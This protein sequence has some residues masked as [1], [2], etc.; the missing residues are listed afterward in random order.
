MQHNVKQRNVSLV[1]DCSRLSRLRGRVMV[2]YYSNINSKIAPHKLK[3]KLFK[4]KLFYCFDKMQLKN[5]FRVSRKDKLDYD[6]LYS[7]IT[8]HA[9]TIR[10]YSLIL[11]I[12]FK[13]Q[14]MM[15]ISPLSDLLGYRNNLSCKILKIWRKY[16]DNQL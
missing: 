11:K 7:L 1:V 12:R 16:V 3:Y 4:F 14:R 8:N 2:A 6:T 5:R 15:L 9:K 13:F 10:W